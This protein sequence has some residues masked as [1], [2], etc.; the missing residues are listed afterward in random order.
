MRFTLLSFVALFVAPV[1]SAFEPVPFQ[2]VDGLVGKTLYAASN[3]RLQKTDGES[4]IYAGEPLTL[5]SAKKW[6]NQDNTLQYNFVTVKTGE[7][8]VGEVQLLFLSKTALGYN[9][10][11]PANAAALA[12]Q[13]FIDAFPIGRRMREIQERHGYD[14]R[15][16][17]KEPQRYTDDNYAYD[18]CEKAFQLATELLRNLD[19]GALRSEDDLMRDQRTR[20]VSFG[21]GALPTAYSKG[22]KEASLKK[23]LKE[24]RDALSGWDNVQ[25]F[26]FEVARL[27]RER[28]DVAWRRG[29]DGV[30]EDKLKKLDADNYAR[31]DRDLKAQQGR[32]VAA[33]A[34]TEMRRGLVR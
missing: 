15:P 29:M 9:L 17:P 21:D 3:Q 11:H 26:G 24:Q 6:G 27:N 13:I 33:V 18:A 22:A 10:R 8:K 4:W 12:T 14:L 30:P 32:L 7:G 19:T 23:R 16:D 5:V 20:W 34:Q 1:A 2:Q 28:R 31:I 25:H